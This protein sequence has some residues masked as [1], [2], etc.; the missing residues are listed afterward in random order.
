MTSSIDQ[1][2]NNNNN[3]DDN[4]HSPLYRTHSPPLGSLAP[5]GG[6]ARLRSLLITLITLSLASL[7]SPAT[8][9]AAAEGDCSGARL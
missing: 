8:A 3:D 4:A 6:A 7:A 2:T 1:T 9:A 5:G